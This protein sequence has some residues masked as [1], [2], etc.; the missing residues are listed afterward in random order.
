MESTDNNIIPVPAEVEQ[1]S[2]VN[3]NKSHYPDS[4]KCH[5]NRPVDKLKERA[6]PK[7]KGKSLHHPSRRSMW[8]GC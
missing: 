8:R 6:A 4:S 2:V 5:Q 1:I 7:R 3:D